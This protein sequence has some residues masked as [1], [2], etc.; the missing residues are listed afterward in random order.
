MAILVPP[1]RPI[2]V[3]GILHLDEHRQAPATVLDDLPA[4]SF[5]VDARTGPGRPPTLVLSGEI[6][7]AAVP[8]ITAGVTLL[9]PAIDDATARRTTAG[10]LPEAQI[11][12]VDLAEVTFLDCAALGALIALNTKLCLLGVVLALE[13]VSQPVLLLLTLTRGTHLLMGPRWKG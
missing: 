12:I 2:V 11:V 3:D 8:A 13:H 1:V 6:D 9:L 10:R 7:I 4:V 5:R